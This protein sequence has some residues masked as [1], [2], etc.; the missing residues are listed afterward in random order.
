VASVGRVLNR[1]GARIAAMLSDEREL[2]ADLSHRLRTPV[3]ALR[4]DVESLTDDD[5]RRRMTD[6]VDALVDAVDIAVSEA[7]LPSHVR[8]IGM[9]DA[10]EVVSDRACFWDV[11]AHETGRALRVDVPEAHAYVAISARELGAALDA[12]V[13]NVFSHTAAG[14]SFGLAVR[15][16]ADASVDIAVED[17]GDG[18]AQSE[19]AERG[20]SSAGSTGIGLDVARR[21]AEHG[22]GELRIEQSAA[23]GARVVLRF[24]G[25]FTTLNGS[26]LRR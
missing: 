2:A 6:H 3:T 19:L 8:E 25:P 15:S 7:R 20:V 12:L 22:H 24:P 17:A 9:S 4:L 23:G 1:L 14:T 16:A 13:D 26:L 10:V 21:A 18:I 11:L 5:E